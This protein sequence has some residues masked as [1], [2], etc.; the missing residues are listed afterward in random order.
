MQYLVLR[1][2]FVGEVLRVQGDVVELPAS[3]EKSSK[4][5][6]LV[7]GEDSEALR[8][9]ANGEYRCSKCESIHRETSKL[10]VRHM[11]YQVE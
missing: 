11:K 6:R 5:F 9:P 7:A 2:C 10:G 8:E 1:D 4:N 3:V